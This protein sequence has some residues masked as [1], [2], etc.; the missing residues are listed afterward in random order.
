MNSIM[1]NALKACG[2]TK[3]DMVKALVVQKALS[4]S[5]VSPQ[6]RYQTIHIRVKIIEIWL[7]WFD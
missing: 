5:G 3:D 6:V 2:L 1:E 4:A 7:S